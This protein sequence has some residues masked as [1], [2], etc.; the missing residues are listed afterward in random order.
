VAQATAT[1]NVSPKALKHYARKTLRLG[2]YFGRPGD[3]RTHPYI[4]ASVLLWSQLLG[5]VLREPS[6]LAMEKRSKSGAGRAL[7]VPRKFGDDAVGYFTERLDPG[8]TRRA[9]AQVLGR[10]KRN[11]AFEAGHG[12]GL[13]LDGTGAGRSAEAHCPLCRP[14]YN[15]DKEVAGYNH[16]VVAITVVGCGL[17]LP[18]DVEPYGPGDC[19]YN[20]GQRLLQRAVPC[21]GARFAEYVVVDGEFATA[22]FLHA[23]NDTGL[24]VVARLKENL[25]ELVAQARK[26]FERQ[27]P[28]HTFRDGPDRIEMWDAADFDPWETLRWPT[29]RVFRY[30]Q[31]KT[32]GTVVDAYWLTDFPTKR[33]TPKM[34][35]RFAK[36]RWE[37]ENPV[38]ND[39]K[40]RFGFE[41]IP[42]HQANSLLLHWLLIFLALCIERLYRLRY[43]HRG[44]HPALTSM[45]LLR[46]LRLSVALPAVIDSG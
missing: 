32:D 33:A 10:A 14:F 45:D 20:A 31:H 46:R 25:P 6:F 41:H 17:T 15:D 3:G 28:Q 35:Y 16:R 2:G 39:S 21:V 7:G 30:R 24:R 23:A 19:E 1:L 11:K 34:L 27:P 8:R 43:L 12:V 9:L 5:Y 42:H 37:V 13:A 18:F 44:V 36:N 4:P 26:R 22:P 29:V 38:F 40:N